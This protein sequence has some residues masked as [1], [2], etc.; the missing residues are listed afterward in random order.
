MGLVIWNTNEPPFV[1]GVGGF[2]PNG[3]G[4]ILDLRKWDGEGLLQI[5]DAEY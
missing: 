5:E 4:P 2:P 3:M 1:K